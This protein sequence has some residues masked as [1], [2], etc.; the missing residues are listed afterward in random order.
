[1]KPN[2]NYI[3]CFF[4]IY[5]FF[6]SKKCWHGTESNFRI[7]IEK[8]ARAIVDRDKKMPKKVNYKDEKVGF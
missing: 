6:K 1:M 7:K 5:F 4:K 8:A 2:F 3:K